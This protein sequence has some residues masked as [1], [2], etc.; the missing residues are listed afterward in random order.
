MFFFFSLNSC[1]YISVLH[2]F[3]NA[4]A[5]TVA[6]KRNLRYVV[7]AKNISTNI[8]NRN[9]QNQQRYALEFVYLHSSGIVFIAKHKYFHW[10][11]HCTRKQL[12]A[13][14]ILFE[15]ELLARHY[16]YYI[17]EMQI[18]KKFI[19]VSAHVPSIHSGKWTVS[20]LYWISMP[21]WTS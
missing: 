12:C 18:M 8:N 9:E 10:F 3:A 5:I 20:F 13:P 17:Y 4:S 14:W 1:V 2:S 21:F 11:E 7:Y 16:Y 15:N 6:S 19:R